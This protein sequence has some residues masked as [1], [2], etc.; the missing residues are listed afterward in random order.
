MPQLL[1]GKRVVIVDDSIVR[2]TTARKIV[3]LVRNA[4]ARGSTCRIS[5]PPVDRPCH[6]GIDTPTRAELVA[7]GQS[8]AAIAAAIEA[9]SLGYLSPEGLRAAVRQ[10]PGFGYCDACFT[11]D[12]PVRPTRPARRRQLRLVEV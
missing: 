12:Y 10:A 8:V 9:D 7:S 11:G 4:G 5:S 1:A 6:Y 2:G 3:R